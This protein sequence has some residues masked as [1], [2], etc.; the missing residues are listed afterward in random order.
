[1]IDYTIRDTDDIITPALIYYKEGLLEN[2][3][4]AIRMAGGADRLWPHVKTHKSIDMVRMLMKLGIRRFKCAQIAELEM[5]CRAGADAAVLSMPPAGPTARRAAAL[6]RAFPDTKLYFIAE[7][8]EHIED[9]SRAASEAGVSFRLLMDVNFD[10]DRTGAPLAQADELFSLAAKEERVEFFGFHCYDGNRH[11]EIGERQ[12]IV[13]EADEAVFSMRDR[14]ISRGFRPEVIIFGGSPSF[15][16]H[17][18]Q[19]RLS[20]PSK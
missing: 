12:K 7:C 16:C 10:M 5:V 3:A 13:D 2:A 20:A 8:K 11:E 15:P 14:L 4:R 9:Y 19:P 17:V 18:R 6:V 1:M